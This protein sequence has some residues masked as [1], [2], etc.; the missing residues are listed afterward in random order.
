M[1]KHLHLR[2]EAH[3]DVQVVIHHREAGDRHGEDFSKLLEPMFDPAFTRNRQ[4]H[5]I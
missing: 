3:Q 4:V 5:P 2:V 1:T